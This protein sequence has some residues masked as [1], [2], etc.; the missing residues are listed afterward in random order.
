[1]YCRKA[2]IEVLFDNK[3]ASSSDGD[4]LNP[5]AAAEAQ[6]LVRAAYD[7][8]GLYF[9]RVEFR[10]D[11]IWYMQCQCVAVIHLYVYYLFNI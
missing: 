1:M 6:V 10:V 11:F 2:E 5:K 4:I 8:S 7:Q 9:Y 3:P